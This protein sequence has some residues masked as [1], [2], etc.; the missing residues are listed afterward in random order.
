M[1][2]EGPSCARNESFLAVRNAL[3]S[4]SS[5]SSL[6]LSNYPNQLPQ[7]TKKLLH[8]STSVRRRAGGGAQ[9]GSSEGQGLAEAARRQEREIEK[10]VEN[11]FFV[12]PYESSLCLKVQNN[13]MH[14]RSFASIDACLKSETTRHMEEAG[15]S[16]A[17]IRA[18][19][20]FTT[21]ERT[22]YCSALSNFQDE[23]VVSAGVLTLQVLGEDTY[24][25]QLV[26]AILRHLVLCLEGG[27]ATEPFTTAAAGSSAHD[28][29]DFLT[30]VVQVICED[31]SQS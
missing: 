26:I 5:N 14:G 17:Q 12:L 22:C 4:C 13:I 18:N 2:G 7:W 24:A 6:L 27:L 9:G 30:P 1:E 20:D 29:Y 11:E 23:T 10:Y 8:L 3:F 21:L 15:A 31:R 19:D 16:W 28:G 25:L